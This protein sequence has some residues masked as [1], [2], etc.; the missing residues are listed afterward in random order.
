MR[1]AVEEKLALVSSEKSKE[2]LI[3]VF[4][5]NL[6]VS[7]L[8]GK[9]NELKQLTSGSKH[10]LFREGLLSQTSIDD[11]IHESKRHQKSPVSFKAQ[12]IRLRLKEVDEDE[13]DSR[14]EQDT[15]DRESYTAGVPFRKPS[16]VEAEQRTKGN[17]ISV[18]NTLSEKKSARKP[19]STTHLTTDTG[20]RARLAGEKTSVPLPTSLEQ[21]T[22]IKSLEKCTSVAQIKKGLFANFI[23]EKVTPTP[24]FKH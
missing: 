23:V 21:V 15:K 8:I 3:E 2:S 4:D 7:N 9:V 19:N 6:N 18:P 14:A 10:L 12:D 16:L 17:A 22:G 11:L 13:F 1:Q 24:L 5:F 20:T